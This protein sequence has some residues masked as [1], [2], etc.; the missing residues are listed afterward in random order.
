MIEDKVRNDGLYAYWIE[1]Y[2]DLGRTRIRL[3]ERR[4]TTPEEAILDWLDTGL[5]NSALGTVLLMRHGYEFVEA[6]AEDC[7][8]GQ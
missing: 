2:R 6:V 4:D 5:P 7:L 8:R 3:G 1:R